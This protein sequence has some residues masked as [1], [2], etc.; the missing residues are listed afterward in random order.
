LAGA[1]RRR[2]GLALFASM[3]L[4][5]LLLL[6]LGVLASLGSF[7]PQGQQAGFYRAYYGELPGKLVVLFSLDHIYKSWWFLGLG[8]ILSLNLLFCSLERLK[9]SPGWRGLGSIMLHLSL[10]VILAGAIIS[11]IGKQH[12]FV[13]VGTGDTINLAE[14]NFPGLTL[15]VR[16]FKIDY[17]ENMQPRQYISSIS[18]Q[19]ADGRVSEK[20][21]QVNHPLKFAGVKIYQ[22]S[23]GW[24]VR[25][26]VAGDGKSLSFEEVSGGRL[27]IDPANNI[28][29]A[30]FFIPDFAEQGGTL[31]TR[32]PLPNNPRL[33]AILFRDNQAIAQEILAVKE[34][35]PVGG[36]AV[37]FAGYRYYTGLEIKKDPGV[38]IIYAGFILLLLGFAVRYLVPE[39]QKP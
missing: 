28:R 20:D 31:Q 18:L 3:K 32:S 35:R 21:I 6:L 1:S 30:F 10:L 12:A 9:K 16:D 13:Q 33:V 39:S 36:Y 27:A 4:G 7:L 34:T 11:G 22:S 29:L 25:G 5:L 38:G 2:Q 26:Q 23:Y 17:Y 24:L 15:T 19:T 14:Q 37:T 8:A